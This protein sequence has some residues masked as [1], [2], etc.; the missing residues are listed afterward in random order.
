MAYNKNEMGRAAQTSLVATTMNK[1]YGWMSLA[2]VVSAVSA[3][4]TA[5]SP[6]LVRLIFSSQLSFWV[7]LLAELGLV[8]YLSTRAMKMSFMAAATC[9]GLYSVVNGVFLSSIFFI[10]DLGTIG[11]AFA[12]TALTFGCMSLIGYTTKKD[13]SGIGSFLFMALI[14]LIIGTLVNMFLKSA[15]FDYIITYAGLFIFVGLTAYDTQKIKQML[16]VGAE[17]GLDMRNMGILG[18]LSLYLDFVNMFLY[19][20]RLFGNRK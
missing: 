8:V 9:F 10:Y 19:I 15:M 1:V 16:A 20:L 18:A 4:Y 11:V 5:T 6:A 12:T 7:L 14:G 17:A 3:V 2:L 13:L